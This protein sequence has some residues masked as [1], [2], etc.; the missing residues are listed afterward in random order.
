MKKFPVQRIRKHFPRFKTR[1]DGKVI[2]Y[3]DNA[4]TSQ[5]PIQVIDAVEDFYR[6]YN[7]NTYQGTRHMGELATLRFE[8][9]RKKVAK[10]INAEYNEIIFTPGTTSSLNML[11]QSLGKNLKKGDEI[12]LTIM[13]HH[14]NL[15][16]WQQI[17][18]EVGAKLRFIYLTLSHYMYF[19]RLDI[20]QYPLVMSNK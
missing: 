10:F 9:V 11:A 5:K 1:V 3:L 15:V 7:A 8:L 12:V 4:A 20:I 13:E 18:K 14:S 19:I 17:A 6:R 2:A 16:P